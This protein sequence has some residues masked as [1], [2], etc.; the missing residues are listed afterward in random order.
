MKKRKKERTQR[1]VVISG[2]SSGLGKE[3]T[4]LFCAGGDRVIGLSRSNPDNFPGHIECD[5]LSLE[6]IKKAVNAIKEEYG[7]V[8]ILINNAGLGI[9]GATEMLPDEKVQEVMDLDYLGALRLSRETLKLM[10]RGGKIVNISSACALFALPYRGVYCSAKAA[11]SMMSHSMR[12]EL[13]KSGIRV[14]NICPGDVKTEF[15]AN[16]LKF[17][18]TN[19]RYGDAPAKSAGYIDGRN[20][21]R[22]PPLKVAK[23][24]YKIALKRNGPQYII[25]AKYKFFAFMQRLLPARWFLGIVNKIFNKR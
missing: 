21:K 17:N 8:D 14:V 20:D 2:G 11:M 15:T 3:L 7:R 12:M 1:V 16:R 22:M 18:E 19:D 25:G 4:A 5:L 6:S 9:S 24:I 10:G 13:S 23:K